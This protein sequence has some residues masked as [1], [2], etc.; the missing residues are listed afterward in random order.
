MEKYEVIQFCGG[1][2]DGEKYSVPKGVKYWHIRNPQ[3][4]EFPKTVD[5]SVS[6]ND[7]FE[8][9]TYSRDNGRMIFNS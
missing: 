5:Q 6:P 1:P 3:K 4:R 8:I 7:T 2:A 9:A